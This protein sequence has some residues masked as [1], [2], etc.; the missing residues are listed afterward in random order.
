M[1]SI[2]ANALPVTARLVPA[3]LS[4][5]LSKATAISDALFTP[6]VSLV[7]I[8]AVAGC[9]ALMEQP[10]E[11]AMLAL[12]PLESVVRMLAPLRAT[13]PAVLAM[14]VAGANAVA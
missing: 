4:M 1:S 6:S 3:K 13:R 14:S 5:V 9:M 8:T 10:L 2:V 7:N 11:P 12:M